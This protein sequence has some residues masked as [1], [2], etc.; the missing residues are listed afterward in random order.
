MLFYK[1]EKTLFYQIKN[2]ARTMQLTKC[3]KS[4]HSNKLDESIFTENEI[5]ADDASKT[6]VHIYPLLRNALVISMF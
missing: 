4:L 1:R 2:E 6:K 5:I 3:Y